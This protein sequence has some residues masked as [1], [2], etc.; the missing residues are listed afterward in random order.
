MK[1]GKGVEPFK[2][3]RWKVRSSAIWSAVACRLRTIEPVQEDPATASVISPGRVI[4][5]PFR[6]PFRSPSSPGRCP[7]LLSRC[8][9]GAQNLEPHVPASFGL[10]PTPVPP[11]L[12]VLRGLRGQENPD[13]KPSASRHRH[14]GQ[15]ATLSVPNLTRIERDYQLKASSGKLVPEA[16]M[17][18]P[19]EQPGPDSVSRHYDD[20][21][22]FYHTG[23]I[24]YG[25]FSICKPVGESRLGQSRE[26]PQRQENR[27]C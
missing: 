11:N 7:G 5:K 9:F 3:A 2:P 14:R 19:L 22:L 13:R 12:R 21:D 26:I 17:I 4:A 15:G 8:T 20:L 16:G 24:Q 23:A 1:T 18:A 10:W 27:S 6:L 25:I